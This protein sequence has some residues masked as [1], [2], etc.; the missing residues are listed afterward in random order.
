MLATTDMP[1]MKNRRLVALIAAV[2]LAASLA[3]AMI[4][5][6]WTA[7]AA[8]DSS[9]SVVAQEEIIAGPSWTFSARIVSPAFVPIL[10]PTTVR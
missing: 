9:T 1:V 4:G 2:F 7:S 10:P 5:N 3:L 6:S 8:P